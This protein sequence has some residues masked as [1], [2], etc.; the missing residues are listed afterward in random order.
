MVHIFKNNVSLDQNQIKDM[1][2][3]KRD[4]HPLN[5]IEGQ[6]YYNTLEKKIYY[7][8]DIK[9]VDVS[10]GFSLEEGDDYIKITID[11]DTVFFSLNDDP[12]EKIKNKQDSL[13]PDGTGTKYP[14]VDA[15][16]TKIQELEESIDDVSGDKNF[17]YHQ[18]FPSST[19]EIIHNLN[20]EP[21]VTIK[22]SADTVVEGQIIINDGVKV[23][24]TF[25]APFT[26]TAILN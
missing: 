17:I 11:E 25:N 19:W 1:V 20:K 22:D 14:T 23:L 13:T 4:S 2:L 24:I 15:V 18:N 3:D 9:W 10:G 21:S 7:R 16:N 12:L 8:D 6:I 26:G 5:G